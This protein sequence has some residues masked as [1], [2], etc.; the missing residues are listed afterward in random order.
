MQSFFMPKLAVPILAVVGATKVVLAS[1]WSYS[2]LAGEDTGGASRNHCE[3]PS[4]CLAEA[5]NRDP[6]R[7]E[8]S[9]ASILNSC[10]VSFLPLQSQMHQLYVVLAWKAI[11]VNSTPMEEACKFVLKGEIVRKK[12]FCFWIGGDWTYGFWFAIPLYTSWSPIVNCSVTWTL[13]FSVQFQA[14]ILSTWSNNRPGGRKYLA[15]LVNSIRGGKRCKP[16]LRP[17]RGAGNPVASCENLRFG[18]L[19]QY[20]KDHSIAIP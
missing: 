17:H 4:P 18:N 8:I 12:F 1:R 5:E 20:Q 14:R 2:C 9:S 11:A 6:R 16:A 13:Q 3:L 7:P 10:R 15:E 19:T